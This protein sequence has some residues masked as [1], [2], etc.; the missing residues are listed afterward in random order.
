M[1]NVLLKHLS[2][3][4]LTLEACEAFLLRAAKLA[5]IR[6]ITMDDWIYLAHLVAYRAT[7]R[8]GANDAEKEA[9]AKVL[10]GMV[11]DK[12]RLDSMFN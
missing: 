3:M 11:E 9:V 5:V 6:E 7:T 2:R 1:M 8:G 10:R 4:T 12:R